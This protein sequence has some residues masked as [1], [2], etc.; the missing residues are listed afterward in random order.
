MLSAGSPI[1][2]ARRKK[3]MPGEAA[4]QVDGDSRGVPGIPEGGGEA[5]TSVLPTG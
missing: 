5:P 2:V 4:A 3:S 1:D